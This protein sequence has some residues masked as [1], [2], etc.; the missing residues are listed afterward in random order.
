MSSYSSS[1]RKAESADRVEIVVIEEI[2]EPRTSSGRVVAI[3]EPN[4]FALQIDHVCLFRDLG[5]LFGGEEV[6]ARGNEVQ[7]S[8]HAMTI[9]GSGAFLKRPIS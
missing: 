1:S 4:T 5:S 8:R 7:M 3:P 2:I 6:F 9:G